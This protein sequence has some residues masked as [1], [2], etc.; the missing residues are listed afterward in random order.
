MIV[1][2]DPSPRGASGKRA[3]AASAALRSRLMISCSI[4]SGSSCSTIS[5][6]GLSCTATLVS[7]AT[8]RSINECIETG[9]SAGGATGQAAGKP[10]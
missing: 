7:S 8:A 3:K 4:W 6:P 1:T 5:G 10:G 2:S 9:C